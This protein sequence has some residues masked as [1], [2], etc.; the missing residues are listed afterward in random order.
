MTKLQELRIARDAQIVQ[1][2]SATPRKSYLEIAAEFRVCQDVVLRVARQNNMRR[3]PG[4][5]RRP[6]R[7]V[8]N[9]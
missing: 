1:A 5:K 9:G 3:S 2:L 8:P 7:E 4:P 6:E